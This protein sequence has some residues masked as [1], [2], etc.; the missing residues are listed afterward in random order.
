MSM[1]FPLNKGVFLGIIGTY[2]SFC[3]HI[4]EQKASECTLQTKV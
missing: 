2:V 1:Y 3:E 4:C